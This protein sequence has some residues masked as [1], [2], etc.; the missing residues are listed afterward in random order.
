MCAFAL[1]SSLPIC[2]TTWEA[3]APGGPS[4]ATRVGGR[5][6][7]QPR[8]DP[9]RGRSTPS[10]SP[11]HPPLPQDSALLFPDDQVQDVLQEGEEVL[12]RLR[13]AR[14]PAPPGPPAPLAMAGAPRAP[15]DPG[16]TPAWGL[17]PAAHRRRSD[18]ATDPP[19][20]PPVRNAPPGPAAEYVTLSVRFIAVP[21]L[22]P[23]A[24]GGLP[25]C[26]HAE[27]G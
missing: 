21:L 26:L 4:L 1:R 9:A 17:R 8:P 2:R 27:W 11:P 12:F 25:G 22:V 6:G 20:S 5:P 16:P 18:G 19:S 7:S 13:S 15:A 24:Q 14:T 23:I 10:A 3:H